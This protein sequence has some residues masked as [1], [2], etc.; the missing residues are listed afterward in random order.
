MSVKLSLLGLRAAGALLVLAGCNGDDGD[1]V[2]TPTPEVTPTVVASPPPEFCPMIDD[3]V[4]QSVVALLE[5]DK[6]SYEQGEP[7]DMTLRLVNCASAP[8][9]RTFPNAQRYDF[10]AKISD[11]DEVWRWSSGMS[12]AEVQGEKTYQ[13]AEQLTFPETWDQ[14]DNEGQPLEPGQYELTTE[15]TGCDES[16]QNCGSARAALFIEITA[17]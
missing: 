15:S 1:S 16:L 13:P 8:I 10:A 7:I 4:V 17:P 14:L 11:G 2:A 5:L 12:F 3:E 6:L 9:T